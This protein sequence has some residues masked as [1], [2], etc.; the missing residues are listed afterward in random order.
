MT[1]GFTRRKEHSKEGIRKAAWE[2]F[3][4]FGIERVSLAD[5]ARKAGVSQATIYNHFGSKDGLARDFVT[6]SVDQLAEGAREVLA[7]D[8]PYQEKIAAF[9]AF[10]SETVSGAQTP[11]AGGAVFTRHAELLNDP[12]IRAIRAAAQERVTSLLL[13]LVEEGKREQQ[14]DMEVSQ[15]ACRLYFKLFMDLFTDPLLQR[16]F[17]R[18]PKLVQDLGSLMMHGLRGQSRNTSGV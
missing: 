14:V 18:D 12:D 16:Q 9:I 6:T 4:Q 11:Q 1:N 2:L 7:A 3:S 13:E 17:I 8:R 5:I 15:E 10:I